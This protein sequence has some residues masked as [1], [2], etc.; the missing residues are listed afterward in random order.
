MV[1]GGMIVDS[2]LLLLALLR[3]LVQVAEM[4]AIDYCLPVIPDLVSYVQLLSRSLQI[5]GALD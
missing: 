2:F 4:V 5:L 1:F 3:V